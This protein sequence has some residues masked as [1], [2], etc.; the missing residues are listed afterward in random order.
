MKNETNILELTGK[1]VSRFVYSHTVLGEE[2]YTYDLAVERTSSVVDTLQIMVSARLINVEQDLIGKFVEI[3]GRFQSFNDGHGHC[4]LY[5]FADEITVLDGAATYK[6]RLHLRGF[7]CKPSIYRKT[8]LGREVTDMC[9]AVNR[10]YGKSDY[11]P[12]IS[13]GRNARYAEGALQVGDELEICGRVQSRTYSKKITETQ[14]EER[15]A[16]EV[17]VS[18]LTKLADGGVVDAR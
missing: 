17:S 5:S 2:F 12:C 1:V 14:S 10:Q 4:K 7:I 16:W 13:W 8:P 15:I 3:K 9:V 11:L 6:N 18:R